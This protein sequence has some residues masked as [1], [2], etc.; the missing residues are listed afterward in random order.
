MNS[1]W[2]VVWILGGSAAALLVLNAIFSG[3]T[4]AAG[5][6]GAARVDRDGMPLR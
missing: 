5:A 2:V 4:S 1:V 3:G 6:A